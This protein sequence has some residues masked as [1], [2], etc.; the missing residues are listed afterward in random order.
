MITFESRRVSCA[1][2]EVSRWIGRVGEEIFQVL[3][4]NETIKSLTGVYTSMKSDK[5]VKEFSLKTLDLNDPYR[6]DPI[7]S[8]WLTECEYHTIVQRQFSEYTLNIHDIFY[9][10]HSFCIIYDRGYEVE[11]MNFYQNIRYIIDM[12]TTLNAEGMYHLDTKSDNFLY[13]RV[14]NRIVIH[15]FGLCY[16]DLGKTLSSDEKRTIFLSQ[17][18]LLFTQWN[19]S[20]PYDILQEYSI[21]EDLVNLPVDTIYEDIYFKNI[22]PFLLKCKCF[23][24][25]DANFHF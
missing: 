25:F 9:D 19:Y 1:E 5:V 21:P 24:V 10:Q 3:Y 8:R 17:M 20:I 7:A 14:K 16:F 13:D 6:Y 22:E 12:I 11:P 18:R 23:D 2:T 15:D 4:T